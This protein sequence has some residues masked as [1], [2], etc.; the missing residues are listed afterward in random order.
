MGTM[1]GYSR[2]DNYNFLNVINHRVH[3]EYE[4]DSLATEYMT[5]SNGVGSLA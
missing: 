1:E 4:K 2:T 3:I 5:T